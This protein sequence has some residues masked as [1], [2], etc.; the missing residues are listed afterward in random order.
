MTNV[1]TYASDSSLMSARIWYDAEL[2]RKIVG[3]ITV[4]LSERLGKGA[5]GTVFKG[6]FEDRSV[7]VK[8]L[9]KHRSSA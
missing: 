3:K 4:F 7:A 6:I 9:Q 1:P 8:R 5:D 2:D